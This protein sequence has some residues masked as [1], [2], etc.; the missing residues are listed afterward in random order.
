MKYF[1]KN[2]ASGAELINLHDLL[3]EAVSPVANNLFYHEAEEDADTPHHRKTLAKS[4]YSLIGICEAIIDRV[5]DEEAESALE[6]CREYFAYNPE[7]EARK[8]AEKIVAAMLG[9]I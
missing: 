1:E 7:D 4:A 8:A 5:T 2:I 6:E 9:R 3:M